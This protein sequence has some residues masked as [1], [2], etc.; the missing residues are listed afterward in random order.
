MARN[1][2]LRARRAPRFNQQDIAELKNIIGEA[3]ELLEIWQAI[4][5]RRQG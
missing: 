5:R 4:V 1:A 3:S 2:I